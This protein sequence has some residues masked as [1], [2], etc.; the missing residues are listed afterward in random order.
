[1][2]WIEFER[3]NQNNTKSEYNILMVD[4]YIRQV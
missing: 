2:D 3:M 1:M 4:H